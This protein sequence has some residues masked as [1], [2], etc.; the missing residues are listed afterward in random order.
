MNALNR[1]EFSQMLSFMLAVIPTEDKTGKNCLFVKIENGVYWFT[2]GSDNY[3][4]RVPLS[5]QS[6]I[7]KEGMTT[8]FMI[9]RAALK[10]FSEIMK[11]HKSKCK[12]LTKENEA[13]LFIF[14]GDDKLES[15]KE[16]VHFEQPDIQY[17]NLHPFFEQ[18]QNPNGVCDFNLMPG[19]VTAIM[20]GFS[21]TKEVQSTHCT[22]NLDEK[23]VHL[24]HFKQNRGDDIEYEAVMLP[25]A[26]KPKE[27]G[28][29]LQVGEGDE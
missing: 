10:A 22:M 17:K 3:M 4:K 27:D 5:S 11:D 16:H 1:Q 24:I 6:T 29:Q 15:I 9:P 12:K 8:S 23:E 18:K 26:E 2:A 20:T 7:E 25:P 21:T 14:I 19:E 13:R 28:E